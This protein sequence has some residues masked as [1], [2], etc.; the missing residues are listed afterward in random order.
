MHGLATRRSTAF[1]ENL[2]RKVLVSVLLNY[3]MLFDRARY[4]AA[5]Q[6]TIHRQLASCYT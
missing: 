1:V 5:D 3:A 6:G 2:A 4:A